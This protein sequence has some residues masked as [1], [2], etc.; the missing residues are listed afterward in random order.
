MKTLKSSIAE[1]NSVYDTLLF[2]F[3]KMSNP[4]QEQVQD[5]FKLYNHLISCDNYKEKLGNT[6]FSFSE[7]YL[8]SKGIISIGDNSI[9]SVDFL[10]KI[11]DGVLRRSSQYDSIEDLKAY[12]TFL[13]ENIPNEIKSPCVFKYSINKEEHTLI[14]KYVQDKNT[15]KILDIV[16]NSESKNLKIETYPVFRLLTCLSFVDAYDVLNI[17]LEK[18]LLT[19]ENIKAELNNFFNGHIKDKNIIQ[20]FIDTSQWGNLVEMMEQIKL[21]FKEVYPLL[22]KIDDVSILQSILHHENINPYEEY[23]LTYNDYGNTKTRVTSIANEISSSD[24]QNKI[25]I[26]QMLSNDFGTLTANAEELS[27]QEFLNILQKGTGIRE[28]KKFIKDRNININSIVKYREN[29]NLSKIVFDTSSWW[30]LPLVIDNENELT[31]RG[32]NTTKLFSKML[33][34][35]E[36]APYA[37]NLTSNILKSISL[38][39]LKIQLDNIRETFLVQMNNFDIK[40]ESWFFKKPTLMY[41]FQP[42]K[43][44]FQVCSNLIL[45]QDLSNKQIMSDLKVLSQD[46]YI[47]ST[48]FNSS[49]NKNNVNSFLFLMDQLKNQTEFKHETFIKYDK[50]NLDT[51]LKKDVLYYENLMFVLTDYAYATMNTNIPNDTII[52]YEEKMLDISSDFIRSLLKSP[53]NSWKAEIQK[54]LTAI[55]FIKETLKTFS[56]S[57]QESTFDERL[58]MND[59]YVD[60]LS[61]F[62]SLLKDE[63]FRDASIEKLR[64]NMIEYSDKL[65]HD[66]LE[67]FSPNQQTTIKVN[68]F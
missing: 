41:N 19:K 11:Q 21:Q 6:S 65:F 39:T 46:V 25:A 48:Y 26:L 23:T 37:N 45:G 62:S 33:L 31:K 7:D 5:S 35:N 9:F 58:F 32:E 27:S 10:L 55:H 54:S 49:F 43:V 14:S 13:V 63:T 2:K 53:N 28:A 50:I 47:N 40:S 8:Q 22:F 64:I 29:N 44:L 17:W 15:N 34:S 12:R 59:K 42:E 1:L 60:S 4:Y 67:A 51:F 16:L 57:E 3:M 68:K 18:S 24:L 20:N 30:A 61:A 36:K 38:D 52:K 56:R 66:S